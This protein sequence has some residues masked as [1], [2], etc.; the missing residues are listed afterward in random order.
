MPS[1]KT[2]FFNI[3]RS[4]FRYQPFETIWY[5]FI[6]GSG[7]KDFKVRSIPRINSYPANTIRKVKRGNINYHLD[8]SDY[9]D[10]KVF[11]D[12]KEVAREKLFEQCKEDYTVVDI[13]TNVGHVLMNF[14]KRAGTNG[15]IIGF[16][17]DPTN[18]K[19][20]KRNLS[21]N[22]F[23][24]IQLYNLGMGKEDKTTFIELVNLNNRGQNRIVEDGSG[25]SMGEK[26]TKIEVKVFDDFCEKELKLTNIDLMK[27]DVEGYEFNVLQGAKKSIEK[28]RPMLFIE[29]DDEYLKKNNGS[30]LQIV[31]FLLDLDYK[32]Y[33]AETDESL[34]EKHNFDR[35][36]FDLFAYATTY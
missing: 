18:F 4:T 27:I 33:H 10:W 19:R 14:A 16:E 29:L 3:L 22:N 11:W 26:F 6:K 5:E 34:D 2:K 17:P 30:A 8:L 23:E 12:L 15:K 35:C 25:G 9:N 21:L 31:Q 24:N 20:C 13:G 1:A 7:Y 36:H 32:I 28:Y